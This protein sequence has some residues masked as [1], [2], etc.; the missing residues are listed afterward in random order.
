MSDKKHKVL[1]VKNDG[2]LFNKVKEILNDSH[3]T[4][5]HDIE[6]I[7]QSGCLG[8]LDKGGNN[9]PSFIICVKETGSTH[10]DIFLKFKNTFPETRRMLI[11]EPDDKNEIIRS[12][13]NDEIHFCLVDPFKESDLTGYVEFG[14]RK[15]EHGDTW[16]YK[17]RAVDEQT[18]KM[19][20][21]AKSCKDKDEDYVKAIEQKK[22]EYHSLKTEFQESDNKDGSATALKKYIAAGKTSLSIDGFKDSFKTLAKSIIKV[23]EKIAKENSIELTIDGYSED[24]YSEILSG[25]YEPVSDDNEN[26]KIINDLIG[27]A[28]ECDAPGSG[29]AESA[30][31]SRVKFIREENEDEKSADI[32]EPEENDSDELI[33][34]LEDVIEVEI[35]NERL[36]VRVEIKNKDSDL[37]NVTSIF[38]YLR[39]VDV[40]YGLVN[41]QM[42]LTWLDNKDSVRKMIVARGTPSKNPVDGTVKYHFDTDFIHAGKVQEDGS[43]DF[44]ERG[45]IPF[46][47]ENTLLAEKT[48]A[49]LG[50][51]G[52]DVSGAQLGVI[53]PID[54]LFV[55]GENTFESEDGMQIFAKTGGQ[56]HLDIMGTVSVAPVLNI[57][58]NVDFETGN[59]FFKGSI[60]VNGAVKEGF[61]VVGTNLTVEQ[62]EGAQINLTGDLNVSAGI[63][64]SEIKTYGNIQAKYI[65]NTSIE[66]HGDLIVTTE[67]LD[68][69]VDSSGKI[70][71]SKVRIIGSDIVAKGGIAAG[72][73]GTVGSKPVKLRVG[74]DDYILKLARGVDKKIN[75]TKDEISRIKDDID[76]LNKQDEECFKSVSDL[77]YTQDRTQLEIKDHK[78]KLVKFESS[79]STADAQAAKNEIQKLE[80]KAGNAEQMV[81]KALDQQDEIANKIKVKEN[82]IEKLE[83][84]NAG[85][86]NEKKALR[87]CSEK[88]NAL[89]RIIVNGKVIA[90]TRIE[91]KNSAIT[92]RDDATRCK[93]EE[94]G[95]GSNGSAEY[96]EI[97]IT[98][99]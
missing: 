39:A 52:V 87:E 58:G 94:I 15:Q 60:V 25:E 71:S 65:N 78:Q 89:A 66:T 91:G 21:K 28:L 1:L 68:S 61:K 47:E 2:T 70:D 85:F 16:E 44:R 74:V 18:F 88:S 32:T 76:A 19:Y 37:L 81:E 53:E 42:L 73:I 7:S 84:K 3:L 99:L 46:V 33:Q 23:F 48:S 45:V 30:E 27:Y 6:F 43:I 11:V 55:A 5:E 8:L 77:A 86:V 41:E 97:L 13:N 57:D 83:E 14:L 24:G 75:I 80:K 9:P 40:N 69:G 34:L 63:I 22:K 96:F 62:I 92:V 90:G 54:P 20:N 49:I 72:Q 50:K 4:V 79:G 64:D 98:N 35:D 82:K 17:K 93:I 67:I 36:N 51:P 59:I 26:N 12:L 31:W 10:K 29:D 56:P 38:E 95:M